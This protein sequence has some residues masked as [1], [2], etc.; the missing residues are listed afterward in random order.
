VTRSSNEGWFE[1]SLS[2]VARSDSPIGY[3]IIQVGPYVRGGVPVLAIRDL[4]KPTISTAHR[5]SPHIDAQYRRSRVT[6]DDI[7]ISVKGTTGRVGIVPDGFEGNISRDVARVRLR[8]DHDPRY[9]LQM[10]RSAEAQQELQL[11]AVGT[12]RQEL[13][14]GPLKKLKFCFPG[15]GEQERI[16]AALADADELVAALEHSITK[17]RALMQGMM[18]Q[19]LTG[20]VRLPGFAEPWH[21][22][23][24]GDISRI[25][26]GSRNNQDKQ[27][28]GKYPFYVRSAV[29]ERINTYSYD[30]EAI[31]VPGEGRIGSILHYVNG[32]FE[33]HQR[34]YKISDF[35]TDVSGRFVYYY[36]QQFFGSHALENSVKATVDSLRLPTFR[37]FPLN[38]PGYDEQQAIAA[39]LDDADA[40]I[41]A[42]AQRLTKARDVKVGM[43]QQLLTGRTRLPVPEAAA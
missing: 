9:W 16:A 12:T 25:K 23:F 15:K 34:V 2:E 18:Q 38:I 28:S 8:E 43:M 32:K 31:L 42:L 20:R 1:A 11:A 6:A 27:A 40:E 17:T 10:L 24:L 29:V 21:K 36:M 5:T 33:V 7:L 4:L 22:T 41:A 35:S 37:G 30:C 13:S 39:A 26:T 19:L 14:I 3:G